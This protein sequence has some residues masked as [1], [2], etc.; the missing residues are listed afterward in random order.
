MQQ[1]GRWFYCWVLRTNCFWKLVVPAPTGGQRTWR[2]TLQLSFLGTGFQ[3]WTGL[4]WDC[5]GRRANKVRWPVLTHLRVGGEV[6][7]L[8][9]GTQL[10]LQGKLCDTVIVLVMDAARCCLRCLGSPLISQ[11]GRCSFLCQCHLFPLCFQCQSPPPAQPPLDSPLPSTWWGSPVS[12]TLHINPGSGILVSMPHRA[13]P[14]TLK[15][16][17]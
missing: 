14:K 15:P 2:G 5:V 3:E 10:L 12:W 9:W 16:E 4:W 6:L 17:Y 8:H 7:V 1:A 11:M 13:K